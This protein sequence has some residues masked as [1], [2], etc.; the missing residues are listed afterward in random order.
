MSFRI[1]R[2]ARKDAGG[3]GRARGLAQTIIL[4]ER[5]RSGARKG[6]VGA[7][8]VPS[9]FTLERAQEVDDSLLLFGAQLIE[10]VDNAIGLAAFA[11]VRQDGL[12]QV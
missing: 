11:L 10:V 8:M 4:A 2:L 3:R 5:A 12:Y 7:A 6:S 1:Y 9:V